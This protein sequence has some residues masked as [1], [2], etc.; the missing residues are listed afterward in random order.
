MATLTIIINDLWEYFNVNDCGSMV[1]CEI[2]DE[3]TSWQ[4]AP[5]HLYRSHNMTD[6]RIIS[7]WNNDNDSIW[8]HFIKK[9]L[10]SAECKFCGN[11]I[12]SAYQK[13]NLDRHLQ[14]THSQEIAAIREEITCTWVSPHFTFDNYNVSCMYCRYSG[15]IYD[16]VSILENHLKEVHN[17]DEHFA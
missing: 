14:F 6:Q 13:Q 1:K 8:Q 17:L 3:S 12:N 11:L 16:V 7:Q 4:R 15:I 5:A 9:D 2:C 10:F